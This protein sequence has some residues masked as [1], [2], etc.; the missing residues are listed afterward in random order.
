MDNKTDYHQQNPTPGNSSGVQYFP[1]FPETLSAFLD[2]LNGKNRSPATVLAYKTDLLQ[3]FRFLQESNFT[4][5]RPADVSRAYITDFLSY[6]AQQKLTGVSRARK[7]AAVREYF[8][9]LEAEG[10]IDRSP[11]HGV[12]G[13]KKEK[14]IRTYLLPDE[15]SRMLSLAGTSPRDFAI[16]Q[17]FLQTG[18]RVSELCALLLSDVELDSQVLHISAGK[19]MSARDIPMEK[20]AIQAIKNWLAIRPTDT[21]NYL[22]LNHDGQHLG[23]RGVRKLVAKYRVLAGITRRASPHSLRH[24]FATYK[25]EKGV[26]PFQLQ[27]WL[28]HAYLNTTQ[29]YVHM[30]RQNAKKLMDATSL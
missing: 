6:L 24:T 9:C 3:F 23:E 20:K 11:T 12:E 27:Q 26:S 2:G 19:G 5:E 17:V 28:G 21:A 7:L 1:A 22:F 16:L 18:V 15:F 4:I 10:K 30:G 8:R 29:I 13:P 14:N 25:A